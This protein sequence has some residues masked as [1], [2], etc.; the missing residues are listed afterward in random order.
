MTSEIPRPEQPRKGVLAFSEQGEG[1]TAPGLG[2]TM[3][4]E[5]P[6]GDFGK[7]W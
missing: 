4:R 1:C 6:D 7:G 2:S 5:V 3:I